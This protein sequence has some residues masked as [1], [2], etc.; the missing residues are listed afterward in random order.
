MSIIEFDVHRKLVKDEDVLQGI[1]PGNPARGTERPSV[2][3]MLRAFIGLN[4][5]ITDLPNGQHFEQIS[6]LN[7][8][9]KKILYLLDLP[10]SIYNK[11]AETPVYGLQMNTTAGQKARVAYNE[12]FINK[13]I[14]TL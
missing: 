1:Y 3:L 5:Y 14:S 11:M 12:P 13:H 9:Q 8:V 2:D 7:D 10:G 4:F 6:P